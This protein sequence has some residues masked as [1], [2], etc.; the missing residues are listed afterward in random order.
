MILIYNHHNVKERE[1]T[2][3]NLSIHAMNFFQFVSTKATHMVLL[4]R[5]YSKKHLTRKSCNGI[6]PGITWLRNKFLTHP[7]IPTPMNRF[8]NF[9]II[10][11]L[12]S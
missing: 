11:V 12:I 3:I 5:S 10:F 2:H 6:E 4:V 9:P 8:I 7:A 1:N